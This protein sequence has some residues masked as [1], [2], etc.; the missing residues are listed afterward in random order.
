MSLVG[1]VAVLLL[2]KKVAMPH[3][4]PQLQL[5]STFFAATIKKQ[6]NML[7]KSQRIFFALHHVWIRIKCN[8]IQERPFLRVCILVET[9][10]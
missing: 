1:R 5:F 7:V 9:E 4:L 10:L 8:Y 6:Q 2:E 3:I